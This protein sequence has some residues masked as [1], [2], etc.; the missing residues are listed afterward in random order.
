[1][2]KNSAT[3]FWTN[4][5]I[6]QIKI[7][8]NLS[9][10]LLEVEKSILETPKTQTKIKIS[11]AKTLFT[12]R[13]KTFV[14]QL[15]SSAKFFVT[16]IALSTTIFSVMMGAM[17]FNAYS[18]RVA[19]WFNPDAYAHVGEKMNDIL[20]NSHAEIAGAR[21]TEEDIEQRAMIEEKIAAQN[22]EMVYSRKYASENLLSNVPLQSAE[23]ASFSVAPQ[24]NR[25][26]IPRL[27][28]NIPL[29]DVYHD[30]NTPF[31]E[32]HEIFK[33]ELTKGIVRYP[34]TA[35]PGEKGNAFI[36]GHSS[37]VPWIKSDYN[38]VF[39][40]L[41]TLEDGDEII[42]YY[43][44]KKFVYKV[45][46]RTTVKPGD[47]EV[48]NARDPNKKEISLMTCWPIGT[49]LERLIIFGELVEESAS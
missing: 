30:K 44:Q 21:Q 25:I 6:F 26:V 41:D 33:Q 2:P 39:A 42:V 10:P 35:R 22:P 32:M 7:H 28:K 8:M 31:E 16:Y 24:E 38:D 36:F 4:T 3:M 47:T 5:K 40:L 34:G 45:T 17:N 46:D 18:A 9:D 14:R 37:N 20:N 48:L 1:M 15:F 13:P 43:N 49:T 11:R 23:K 19:H 29:I 27:A 12:T